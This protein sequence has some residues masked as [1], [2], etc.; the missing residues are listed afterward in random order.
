[1]PY[2]PADQE[3]HFRTRRLQILTADGYTD[4]T[5]RARNMTY[6]LVVRD[7]IQKP[8]KILAFY[9]LGY[10]RHRQPTKDGWRWGETDNLWDMERE[11]KKL[12]N[13]SVAL[14]LA[15]QEAVELSLPFDPAKDVLNWTDAIKGV[16]GNCP[17]CGCQVEARGKGNVLCPD[18]VRLLALGS[19]AAADS[20]R[21]VYALAY[22]DLVP[23]LGRFTSDVRKEFSR[24]LAD[25]LARLAGSSVGEQL[26]SWKTN[27]DRKIPRPPR[28]D[29]DDYRYA[30]LLSDGQ[31]EAFRAALQVLNELFERYYLEGD[32]NGQQW[33]VNLAAGRFRVEE[34]QDKQVKRHG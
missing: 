28:S 11:S 8:N 30:I 12:G 7:P 3:A 25:A 13:R 14:R 24:Q 5:G 16:K 31:A 15:Q 22:F 20:Q 21:T 4:S 17:A 23:Y 9:V 6:W 32:Q 18:C 29:R 2:K 33:L 34:V 10:G 1:M 27:H 26:E 19:A